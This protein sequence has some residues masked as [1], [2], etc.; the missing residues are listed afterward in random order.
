MASPATPHPPISG[1]PTAGGADKEERW[2]VF[3]GGKLQPRVAGQSGFNPSSG[4]GLRFP[5][6]RFPPPPQDRRFCPGISPCAAPLPTSAC[7]LQ[8]N[9]THWLSL[10]GEAWWEVINPAVTASNIWRPRAQKHRPARSQLGCPERSQARKA[11][12]RLQLRRGR[13]ARELPSLGL[14]RHTLSLAR[15]RSLCRGRS[16]PARARPSISQ[17]KL[18]RLA[19]RF[20]L[21]FR[22]TVSSPPPPRFCL[23]VSRT[24]F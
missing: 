11:D 18:A 7:G 21:N 3:P 23:F 4:S 5:G 13:R 24:V 22:G 15:N 10:W 9:L 12:P 2:G 8:A 1:A 6:L 16:P 19:E 20:T 14:Q 17:L